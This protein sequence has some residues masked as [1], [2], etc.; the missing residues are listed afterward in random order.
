MFKF[1]KYKSSKGVA[2]IKTIFVFLIIVL[3]STLFADNNKISLLVSFHFV[4]VH[5]KPSA[6]SKQIS[7]YKFG[8]VVT[9]NRIIDPWI[10]INLSQDKN[11]YIFREALVDKKSFQKQMKLI[12]LKDQKKELEE[13]F[14]ISI[15]IKRLNELEK[16]HYENHSNLR[17][18]LV[19]RLV[20][21]GEVRNPQKRFMIWR[22]EG[23][24]GEYIGVTEEE[25]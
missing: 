8:K 13:D 1:P 3:S 23:S 24:L 12:R 5:S 18:D 21:S 7:L 10:E 25:E 11:G 2:M 20:R 9:V 4:P 6:F 16:K 22:K 17:Y 14:D 15:A 19:N